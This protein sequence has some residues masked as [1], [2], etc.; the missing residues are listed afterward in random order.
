MLMFLLLLI[1]LFFF[2]F[3][4][5]SPTFF[6]REEPGNSPTFSV[7]VVATGTGINGILLVRLCVAERYGLDSAR[8]QATGTYALH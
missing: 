2:V 4:V 3:V 7:R 8:Y 5:R 6:F 1:S